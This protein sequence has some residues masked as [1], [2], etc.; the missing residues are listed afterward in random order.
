MKD[1]H[2]RD[3][4][5]QLKNTVTEINQLMEILQDSNVEVRITYIEPSKENNQK[6]GISIWRIT[7][8]NDYL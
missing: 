1:P 7:E 5:M 8:H 3:L 2:I 6:Q 4:V